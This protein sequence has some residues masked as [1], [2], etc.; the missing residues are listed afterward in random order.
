MGCESISYE[1]NSAEFAIHHLECGSMETYL[2]TSVS[3]DEGNTC[4][5]AECNLIA[6]SVVRVYVNDRCEHI[7]MACWIHVAEFRND[8]TR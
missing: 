1:R 2:I 3:T 5:A 8:A 4:N 7:L 6:S